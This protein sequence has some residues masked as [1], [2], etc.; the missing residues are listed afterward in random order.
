[1][2]EWLII[3]FLAGFIARGDWRKILAAMKELMKLLRKRDDA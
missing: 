1:M 3:G 2:I